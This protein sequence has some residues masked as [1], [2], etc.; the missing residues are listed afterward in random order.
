MAGSS[1]S[2]IW[3]LNSRNKL[4]CVRRRP[5]NAPGRKKNVHKTRPISY[6]SSFFLFLPPCVLFS[7][8]AFPSYIFFYPFIGNDNTKKRERD[9][10][11]NIADIYSVLIFFFSYLAVSFLLPSSY[12]G[13]FSAL[14]RQTPTSGVFIIP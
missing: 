5:Y 11:A 6:C 13:F 3:S 10:P 4:G 14:R 2:I 7:R 8:R 9:D 12:L 1:S